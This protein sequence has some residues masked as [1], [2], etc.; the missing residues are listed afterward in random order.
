[1]PVLPDRVDRD[2]PDHAARRA[3]LLELLSEHS[4]QLEL[5]NLGGG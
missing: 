5:A 4:R 3:S 2:A 1:M